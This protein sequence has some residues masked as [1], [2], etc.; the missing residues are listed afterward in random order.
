VELNMLAENFNELYRSFHNELVRR[1]KAEETMKAARDEAD[2][3]N[4]RKANF[5]PV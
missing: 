3:A 1:K 4:R 5:L 2:K